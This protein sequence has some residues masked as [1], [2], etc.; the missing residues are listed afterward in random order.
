MN[1]TNNNILYYNNKFNDYKLFINNPILNIL[2]ASF[3]SHGFLDFITLVPNIINNSS[4]YISFLILFT[5]LMVNIPSVT[6]CLFIGISMYHFGEDFRY[7]LQKRENT[8]WGGV[9]LFSSSVI[10]GYDIWVNTL[11]YLNVSNPSLLSFAVL[12][13][14][15]PSAL[16]IINNPISIISP[17][18]IGL[19]GPVPNLILYS[20]CIHSPLAVYRYILSFNSKCEKITCII[21][22]VSGTGIVYFFIPYL[23][24]ITPFMINFSISFV[25]SHV[26]FVTKWQLNNTL[27]YI[28]NIPTIV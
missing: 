19:G 22:W 7:I 14:G 26:I 1:F 21:V 3:I 13:M 12:S 8:R 23:Q 18:I 25:I 6:I 28:K 10:F 11:K 20:C 15:I 16:H 27:K 5:T 24:D 9:M 17:F 4:I 2:L